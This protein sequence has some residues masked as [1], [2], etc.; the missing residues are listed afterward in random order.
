M[1]KD[2]LQQDESG[3]KIDARRVDVGPLKVWV[4][5]S[6]DNDRISAT[7]ATRR[8][9]ADNRISVSRPVARS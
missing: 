2:P 8:V 6:E 7:A 3:A 4:G 1:R 5:T 9:I